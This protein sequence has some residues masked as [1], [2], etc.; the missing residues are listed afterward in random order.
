MVTV[1]YGDIT[2][3]SMY[4]KIFTII[5]TIFSSANFGYILNV[6]GQIFSEINLREASI[7]KEKYLMQKYIDTHDI[8]KEL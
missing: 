4:E 3:I 1:G 6:I 8:D 5:M 2:P 7:M